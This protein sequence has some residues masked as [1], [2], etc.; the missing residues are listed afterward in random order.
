MNRL[1]ELRTR[2]RLKQKDIA[3]KLQTT[4]QTVARWET[5]GAAIPVAQLKDLATFFGCSVDELLGI[6]RQAYQLRL[7]GLAR[8]EMTPPW[9]TVKVQFGD[10]ERDYPIA[11]SDIA[12][13]R[14]TLDTVEPARMKHWIEF[15]A[16]DN[17]LVLIN[18]S[19]VTRLAWI[20]DDDDNMPFFASP[21]TYKSLT[22]STNGEDLG[23]VVLEE[24]NALVRQVSQKSERDEL[25]RADVDKVEQAMHSLT[26]IYGSG[27]SEQFPYVEATA[28]SLQ[29]FSGSSEAVA[30]NTFVMVDDDGGNQAFINCSAVAAIEIPWEAHLGYAEAWMS[31]LTPSGAH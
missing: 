16:L 29:A 26:V 13:L 28:T 30:A 10:L 23:P 6:E 15:V 14:K 3:E 4:Q 20:S 11:D 31:D 5:G 19:L 18:P 25:T 1:K 8:A 22:N 7:E 2:L 24:R 27:R 9:G 17:R 21:E 12:L